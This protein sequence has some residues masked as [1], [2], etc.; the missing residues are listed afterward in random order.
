MLGILK[1]PFPYLDIISHALVGSWIY[2]AQN[3]VYALNMIEFTC[4]CKN[5]TNYNTLLKIGG[6]VIGM[7]IKGDLSTLNINLLIFSS[8][9]GGKKIILQYS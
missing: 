2:Y 1:A 4:K 3:L 9:S 5:R 7:L 6:E 8:V